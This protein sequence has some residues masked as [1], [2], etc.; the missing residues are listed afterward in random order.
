MLQ[1][2]DVAL[3]FDDRLGLVGV[4]L[5]PSSGNSSFINAALFGD[6]GA[7]FVRLAINALK[8]GSS[9]TIACGTPSSLWSFLGVNLIAALS[10]IKFP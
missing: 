3:F 2:F 7:C 4:Q 5:F 1:S 10:R 6:W 8:V 9:S